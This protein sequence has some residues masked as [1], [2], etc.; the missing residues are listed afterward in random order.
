MMDPLTTQP[1]DLCLVYIQ[2][3]VRQ[4]ARIILASTSVLISLKGFSKFGIHIYRISNT[5][6]KSFVLKNAKFI[7]YALV[8]SY[9]MT[10]FY[11]PSFQLCMH[12]PDVCILTGEV[13][14]SAPGMGQSWLYVQTGE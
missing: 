7:L 4:Y 9:I 10:F 11:T 14:D 3:F 2:L 13:M 6:K 1:S 5:L 8:Y 12:I